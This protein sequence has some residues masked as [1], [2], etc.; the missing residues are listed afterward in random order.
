MGGRPAGDICPAGEAGG[1]GDVG[2]VCEKTPSELPI[3]LII[4]RGN[5][6]AAVIFSIFFSGSFK[7]EMQTAYRISGADGIFRLAAVKN[8]QAV[9]VLRGRSSRRENPVETKMLEFL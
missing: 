7:I 4:R 2:D 5:F 3:K 8:H 9:G 1:I 6:T